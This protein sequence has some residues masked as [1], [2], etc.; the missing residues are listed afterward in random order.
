MSEATHRPTTL[1]DLAALNGELAALAKARIPLEPELRRLANQLQPGAGALASRLA[2]RIE[3]G[4]SLAEALDAEGDNLPEVY[5][6]VVEAG[7]ASGDPSAALE[8]MA[9]SSQRL[10][11]L[12]R[13]TSVALL[14]PV[15][16]IIIASLLLAV[17]VVGVFRDIGWIAPKTLEP[18][19]QLAGNKWLVRT[20]V[21]VVPMLAIVVPLLWWWRSR[22]ATSLAAPR[23]WMLGWIPGARRLH[24]LSSSATMAEVL[25]MAAVAGLPLDR[26]LRIAGGAVGHRG[27][28][29]AALEL[30]DEV[31]RGTSPGAGENSTGRSPLDR[32]PPLV[33]VALRQSGRRRLMTASLDRAAR[34]Y[35]AR[36]DLLQSSL[37]DFIPA[38]LTV[39]V[40][41]TV[42]AAY[43]I[44][45]MWSY[46][47][48]LH[49]L[50]DSLWH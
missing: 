22:R 27:Y 11:S 38:V 9:R 33:Q 5:R 10:S 29:R 44:G 12:Q 26:S 21:L 45:M 1:D 6:A 4:S 7:L 36:A 17:L 43:C 14:V 50:A 40:A 47:E 18:Y 13:T 37:N 19:A 42:V 35:Q 39:G 25:R 24:R 20:L 30:A 32:L 28:R 2:D 23:W 48:M 3:Q 16:V 8:E 41:G 49:T 31:T 15:T 46:A 34:S